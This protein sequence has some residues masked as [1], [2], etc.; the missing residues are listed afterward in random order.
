MGERGWKR[1]LDLGDRVFTTLAILALVAMGI[2]VCADAI[3]RYLFHSPLSGN[4]EFTSLYAMV[5]LAFMAM[6]G[7]YASGGHIR[8]EA[9]APALRRIPWNASERLN[10]AFGFAAFGLLAWVSGQ[11]AFHKFATRE[12]TLGSIQFPM[13]WSYVWVPLG[14]AWLTARLVF[15]F[16]YPQEKPAADPLE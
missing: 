12:T 10:I 11:E 9:F 16:F 7:T 8:M 14:S 5:V 2:S 4:Y 3:G 15:E 1:I 6:P 13:Y